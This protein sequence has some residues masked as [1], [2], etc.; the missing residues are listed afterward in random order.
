MVAVTICS[1]FGAQENKICEC[2]NICWMNT[3]MNDLTWWLHTTSGSQMNSNLKDS[4][5]LSLC[6]ESEGHKRRLMIWRVMGPAAVAAAFRVFFLKRHS[7]ALTTL[8]YRLTTEL[9]TMILHMHE[10]IQDMK[11]PHFICSGESRSD[12]TTY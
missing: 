8:Y 4:I 9:E 6:Q 5:C 7:L 3:Q 12:F 1:D 2:P 11:F 10:I